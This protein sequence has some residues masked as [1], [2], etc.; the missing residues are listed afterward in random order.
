MVLLVMIALATLSISSIEVRNSRHLHYQELAQAN[1]R[2]ALMTAIGE[3][4]KYAGHDQRATANA[5]I[6]PK[7]HPGKKHILGVWSTEQWDP[8]APDDK[9]LLAWLATMPLAQANQPDLKDIETPF[10][11]NTPLIT[12]VGEGSLGKES[13]ADDH[14]HVASIP[15][16]DQTG[17]TAGSYAFWVSDEASKASYS[18]PQT[19]SPSAWNQAA[20]LGTPP[21]TGVEL[22]E[23]DLFH[24]YPELIQSKAGH[25]PSY[26]SIDHLHN[27]GIKTSQQFF[28]HLTNRSV[29][30]LT[31][32][33]HGGL[34]ADLSTA[35][36]LELESFNAI[37]AFHNSGEQNNTD[38]YDTLNSAQYNQ[39]EFYP[40]SHPLGYLYLT[41]CDQGGVLR[42]P[43]WDLLRNHYRIYKNDWEKLDWS[44]GFK[45]SEDAV[46]ARGTLPMS[47]STAHY[48]NGQT[49]PGPPGVFVEHANL[50]GL[51][52]NG[53]RRWGAKRHI[54]EPLVK[55]SFTTQNGITKATA[56]RVAPLVIRFTMVVGVRKVDDGS[57]NWR[58][59][60]S[61]DP[62]LT[63]VN[64][65]NRAIEFESIGL[66]TAKYHPFKFDITYTD[67]SDKE[68]H[69]EHMTFFGNWYNNGAMVMRM[70]GGLYRL[71]PGEVKVMCPRP[72]GMAKKWSNGGMGNVSQASFEY[73]DNSGIYLFP[74]KAN[75]GAP[76]IRPKNGTRVKMI[77][78]GR[79]GSSEEDAVFVT[80]HYSKDHNGSSRNLM[81]HLPPK[82]TSTKLDVFDDPLIC[83][84][85]YSTWH[86]GRDSHPLKIET[87]FNLS[88]VPDVGEPGFHI[89]A[90]DVRMRHGME[91]TPVFHQFSPRGQIFDSLNFDGS[92]RM[93]PA[94]AVELLAISDVSELALV[95]ADHEAYWGAGNDASTGTPRVVLYELPTTPITSLASLSQADIATLPEG[96][97]YH[98]G[99]SF[100]HPGIENLTQIQGMSP[101]STTYAKNGGR[102]HADASW[103]ANEAIWD[104]YFFSGINW[105][106]SQLAY[107]QN[108][109]QSYSYQREAVTALVEGQSPA[110]LANPRI[111]YKPST[112]AHL[113]DELMA[114]D[115]IA[116]HL[117]ITGGF[118]VNSTSVEAWT[119]VLSSL[120]N[121]NVSYLN[122]NNRVKSTSSNNPYSRS[123]LPAG[124]ASDE[125]TGF[126][127][128]SDKE[129]EQLAREIVVQVKTRGPFMGM[130]DFVNRRLSDQPLSGP[131]GKS[132]D[133]GKLG[134]LQMAIEAAGLN[135]SLRNRSS[136]P[137][138][139]HQKMKAN[140]TSVELSTL[141]GSPGYLMQSDILTSIGSI[142]RTRSDTFLIRAYGDAKTPDGS[143]MAK[144]WCEATVQRSAEW[145]NPTDKRFKIQDPA[146]PNQPSNT[147]LKHWETNPD[148]PPSNRKYGR[149][150]KLVSFRW[151]N[152][153]E[154]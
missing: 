61:L 1:A 32:T 127:D 95:G 15:I 108:G 19:P 88:T 64:P 53:N 136:V 26:Q 24:D 11:S 33:R 55:G 62:Y 80:Q 35:F 75:K 72:E 54:H 126:R 116:K 22:L 23:P 129:I 138:A 118:N 4:Q 6:H 40:S 145:L 36:E 56:A 37:E 34:K 29:S 66:Y 152:H 25:L 144:A 71:E 16:L 31:N 10:S 125:W 45:S 44:R 148:F 84:F 68:K 87:N 59:A 5:S 153:D 130:A 81:A 41:P 103:A 14:V 107:Q 12:M 52:G 74:A 86:P 149:K 109:S 133:V 60:F 21:R 141:T 50:G 43:T 3:L 91:Q 42:G 2:M 69:L 120:K 98:I 65:Y 39:A 38:N 131:D 48:N 93:T 132:S 137:N 143:I 154:I 105:G 85:G 114:Y 106:D 30:L 20:A 73:N 139:F 122:N 57:G 8:T 27:A 96:G 18:V 7:A 111:Q 117:T 100:P 110:P 28:H 101:V 146:Y 123:I 70:P 63:L 89:A 102:H 92:D 128:L 104:Q 119:A 76:K 150:I 140:G 82:K 13:P 9:Q 135:D 49:P 142:L 113:T 47:Y 121:K 58:L 67:Q 46:Q 83:R 17:D 94:W 124:D 97:S 134:A 77:V 151:L 90:L 99:N 147:I 112:T 79:Y 78:T 115:R 51:S